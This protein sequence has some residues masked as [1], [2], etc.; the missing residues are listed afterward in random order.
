[1][2]LF[3]QALAIMA[4][5]LVS[6]LP[7]HAARLP[8][9]QGSHRTNCVVDGDTLWLGGVKIRLE[10]I[11]T[12]EI[13][14]PNCSNEKKLG[15]KAR[16][17]LQQILNTHAFRLERRGPRDEDRYGRKL[18]TLVIGDTSA[19]AML[20]SEGLARLWPDGEEFWCGG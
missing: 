18:R 14:R 9:C 6:V 15:L 17:R 16:D 2:K 20:V 1:M 8:V 13:S 11:D 12:P 19:G 7:A 5:V 3:S 4:L 10:G